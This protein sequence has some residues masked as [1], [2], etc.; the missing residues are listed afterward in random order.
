MTDR[1]VTTCPNDAAVRYIWPGKDEAFCCMEHAL[2]IKYVADAMGCPVH[3]HPITPDLTKA[4][5]PKC[6]SHVKEKSD[7]A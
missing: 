3:M 5:W 1:S 2:R 4:G 7:V 6:S